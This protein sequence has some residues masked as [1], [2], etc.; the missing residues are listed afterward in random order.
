LRTKFRVPTIDDVID[1]AFA[2]GWYVGMRRAR[3]AGMADML[4]FIME[5]QF[6][7]PADTR[8]MVGMC[9]SAERLKQWA[10]RLVTAQSLEDIFAEA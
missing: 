9:A 7:V 4:L 2:Q 1:E 3:V 10:R 5:V 8:A 6:T